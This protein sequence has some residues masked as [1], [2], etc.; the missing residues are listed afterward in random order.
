[1]PYVLTSNNCRGRHI[2][3]TVENGEYLQ[4]GVGKE[5]SG[6][7]A[8][9]T[10]ENRN[11]RRLTFADGK[12]VY[13]GAVKKLFGM[14]SGIMGVNRALEQ[15]KDASRSYAKGY[16]AANKDYLCHFDF[17]EDELR[18]GRKQI[19]YCVQFLG[20]SYACAITCYDFSDYTGCSYLFDDDEDAEAFAKAIGIREV[21]YLNPDGSLMNVEPLERDGKSAGSGQSSANS[22]FSID[23]SSCLYCSACVDVCPTGAISEGEAA[24]YVIDSTACIGCGSCADCCPAGAIQQI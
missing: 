1:M 17:S 10:F 16:E 15:G 6:V 22:G 4:E 5:F 9:Q 8:L 20:L 18:S 12:N 23:A 2:V 13:T 7:L 21:E 11:Y 14:T 3:F 19:K 24:S